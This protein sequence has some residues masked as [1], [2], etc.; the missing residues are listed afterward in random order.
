MYRCRWCFEC[1][2]EVGNKVGGIYTVIRS[3]TGVSTNELGDQGC[4]GATRTIAYIISMRK[5]YSMVEEKFIFRS[6]KHNFESSS[7]RYELHPQYVLLGPW[8]ESKARQE[9]EQEDFELHHPLG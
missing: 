5:N 8:V 3:K 7:N 4:G 6:S 2:W 1:A 9:V